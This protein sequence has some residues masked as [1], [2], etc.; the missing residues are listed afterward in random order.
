MFPG[1]T[2]SF[3]IAPG[4]GW[5]TATVGIASSR[6]VSFTAAAVW[7]RALMPQ[8]TMPAT[9]STASTSSTARRSALERAGGWPT[10]ETG[11]L[12][13]LFDMGVSSMGSLSSIGNHPPSVQH[14]EHRGHEKQRR[15]GGADQSTDHRPAQRGIL[16][17]ALPHAHGHRDHTDD[18][19]QRGHQHGPET[20]EAGFQS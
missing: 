17:A 1:S 12:A 3:F 13:G 11:L 8:K 19:G 5:I 15:D 2:T 14:A 20:R 7:M 10:G 4:F 6:V 16:L 18:H 9:I